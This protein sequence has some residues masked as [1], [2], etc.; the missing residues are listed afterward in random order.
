LKESEIGKHFTDDS[1][2]CDDRQ[3]INDE[4]NRMLLILYQIVRVT[5][6]PE[7]GDIG[8]GMG[9]MLMQQSRSYN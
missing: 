7:T 5:I 6:D 9:T 4:A 3:S 1:H 2:F 8:S